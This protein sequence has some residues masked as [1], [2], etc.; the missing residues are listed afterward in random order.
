MRDALIGE[1]TAAG[2]RRPRLPDLS[3]VC[4]GCLHI[5]QAFAKL[6]IS[7][8]D[9]EKHR[10]RYL[11]SQPGSAAPF[12]YQQLLAAW[13]DDGRHKAKKQQCLGGGKAAIQLQPDMV[14]MRLSGFEHTC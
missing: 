5:L 4:T 2:V 10:S 7:A 1:S 12:L 14:D 13:L 8:D 11:N 3:D 6:L 9:L